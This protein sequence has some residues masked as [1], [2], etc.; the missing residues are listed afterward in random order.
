MLRRFI[1]Y[2]KPYHKML[3]LDM[4]AALFISLIGMV[5]PIVTNEM[6][7]RLIPQRMYKEIVV[8]DDGVITEKGSH[9]KLLEDKKTYASLYKLQ[10]REG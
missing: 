9:E 6:L 2:Y 7:E 3:S 8:I 1:R 5:Y 4:L 10:F